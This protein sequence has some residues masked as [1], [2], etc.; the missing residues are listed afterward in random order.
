MITKISG[1]KYRFEIVSEK[2][3]QDFSFFIKAK[4]KSTGRF[5]CINNLNVV[6]SELNV[7][8]NDPKFSDSKWVVTKDESNYFETVAK[9]FLFDPSFFDYLERKLDEDRML[10]EWENKSYTY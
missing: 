8:I 5:S 1:A 3:E 4:S 10:G 9:R 7:D 6:L 2:N